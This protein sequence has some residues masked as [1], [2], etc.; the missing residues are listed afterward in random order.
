[1]D[2]KSTQIELKI[3]RTDIKF[4]T[5]NMLNMNLRQIDFSMNKILYL[6]DEICE[7]RLLEMLKVDKN[8]LK[9]LPSDIGNL[10]SLKE[11]S[12]SHNDLR[13]LPD[14]LARCQ[15]LEDLIINDN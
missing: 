4:I 7:L 14:D 8:N 10:R 6:P 11:L 5:V 13:S 9:Q 15:Q 12:A 2:K 1:M 3:V